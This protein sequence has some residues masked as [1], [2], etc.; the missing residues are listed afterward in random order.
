V[1][2]EQETES[3]PRGGVA[4]AGPESS[5]GTPAKDQP[6]SFARVLVVSA[7]PD[8]PEFSAGASIAG[9]A[10]RG[11][12]VYYCICT[13]GSQGGEDPSV[14]DGE[15][16]AR[17]YEE[18]RRAAST[19]GVK[20]VVFLGFRDGHLAANLELRR[21]ITSEI[22]RLQPD[23]VITHSPVRN[24]GVGIGASHPDHLAVGEAT[25]CSVYPDARNPRA[26]TDLL[27]LGLQPHK[28]KEVWVPG[29][30]HADHFV[31]VDDELLDL[32]FR[33]IMC[34]ASQFEKPG[35]NFD[36]DD[37]PRKWITDR[38]RQAGEKG[39]YRYAEAFKRIETA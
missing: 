6:K 29:Y 4:I 32:K 33:S 36:S 13:D 22:R 38:M 25:L 21:A 17:R 8:D 12:E 37:G 31:E 20:D 19:L 30:E 23:L 10:R 28:V 35:I 5:P 9:L 34:H 15:L 27:A 7:H 26:F 18:Q 14:P 3:H 16:S 39:G 1:A 24:L 2:E 11:S